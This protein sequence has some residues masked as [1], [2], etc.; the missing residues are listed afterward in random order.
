M[1]NLPIWRPIDGTAVATLLA[2]MFGLCLLQ[3][4][5]ESTEREQSEIA[6][7]VNS[8]EIE[9]PKPWTW[10]ELSK[11]YE[12]EPEAVQKVIEKHG[13]LHFHIVPRKDIADIQ[14]YRDQLEEKGMQVD[15]DAPYVWRPIKDLKWFHPP[16]DQLQETYPDLSDD[17][18][19]KRWTEDFVQ[20][21]A[22][23]SLNE[24]K[25]RISDYFHDTR[26][27][28][29]WLH[30]GQI[31]LLVSNEK[32]DRLSQ[33]DGPWTIL[34]ATR[35]QDRRGFAAI[36]LS[37]DWVAAKRMHELSTNHVGEPMA[38]VLEGKVHSV[39]TFSGAV[40]N[41]LVLLKSNN[42]FTEDELKDYLSLFRRAGSTLPPA[43]TQTANKDQKP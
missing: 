10:E 3:A 37:L 5:Q 13:I 25:Q 8:E 2:L 38:T 20:K 33:A 31:Y 21:N 24:Y 16:S 19:A 43:V 35:S 14:K 40:S 32:I 11:R 30:Q 18:A 22:G 27:F 36:D 41:R 17:E 7:E 15:P 42:G 12:A 29:A 1:K 28:H 26:G 9:R 34:S 39:R 4:C 6:E 23:E